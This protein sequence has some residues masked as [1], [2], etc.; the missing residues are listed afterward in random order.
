M[1]Q[2]EQNFYGLGIA[3]AILSVI[4]RLKF[5]VP[6]KIQFQAIP[7]GLQGQDVM[8]IAQTGTGKTIA[9]GIP[10][11]QRLAQIKGRALI[12]VGK[13]VVMDRTVR[14]VHRYGYDNYSKMKDEADKYFSVA[15]EIIGKFPEVAGL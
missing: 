2:N 10:L 1:S 8:G 3:P 11:I 12:V 9:F 7:I 15:L 13:L 14:D 5:T 4:E 6:T